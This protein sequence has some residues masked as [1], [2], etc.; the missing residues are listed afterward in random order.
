MICSYSLHLGSTVFKRYM[1]FRLLSSATQHRSCKSA[2]AGNILTRHGVGTLF[3]STGRRDC[4]L[5]LRVTLYFIAAAC[6][7]AAMFRR[8][9][10]KP[11]TSKQSWLAIPDR[12]PAKTAACPPKHMW[13]MP[14]S[15]GSSRVHHGDTSPFLLLQIWDQRE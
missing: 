1:L 12:R 5:S 2:E 4:P 15:S 13:T 8:F 3:H 6:F 9:Q 10:P 11:T 14:S 7:S